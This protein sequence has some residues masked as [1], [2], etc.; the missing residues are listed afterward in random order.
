[1]LADY[2]NY[3][4]VVWLILVIQQR[5]IGNLEGGILVE[6]LTEGTGGRKW[7]WEFNGLNPTDSVQKIF[8]GSKF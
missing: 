6:K 3:Q 4:E 1:M 7:I 2:Q 8:Q 5:F